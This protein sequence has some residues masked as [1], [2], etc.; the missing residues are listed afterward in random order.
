MIYS[1]D[2]TCE[3]GSDSGTPVSEDDAGASS[4]FTGVVNWVELEIG[5]DKRDRLITPEERMRVA[6]SIQ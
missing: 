6:T 1:G 2:E 4:R 5:D 3:I